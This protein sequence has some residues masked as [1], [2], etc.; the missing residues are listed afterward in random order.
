M[1]VVWAALITLLQWLRLQSFFAYEFEDDALY[2]QLLYNIGQGH[3]FENSIHPGHRPSHLVAIVALLWPFYALLGSGHVALMLIKS[4]LVG[5]GA[6]ALYLLGRQCDLSDR[7]AS[8][9]AG[10]YLLCPAT[11]ALALS[12]FRPLAISVGPLLFL[13]W[14]FHGKRFRPFMGLAALTLLFREDLGVT[15]ALFSLVAAIRK[16]SW[17]WRIWPA[18]IGIV[19]MAFVT[20]AIL[21]SG[22]ADTMGNTNVADAGGFTDRIFQILDPTHIAAGLCLMLP[23]MF[24]PLG[25]WEVLIGLLGVAAIL[26]NRREFVGNLV[27]LSAPAVAACFGAAVIAFKKWN[28]RFPWLLK[29][30]VAAS[31]LIHVQ[32]WIPPTFTQPG[33]STLKPASAEADFRAAWSPFSPQ[34]YTQSDADRNRWEAVAHIPSDAVVSATGHFLPALM[35]RSEIYEVGHWK[36]PWRTANYFI[37]EPTSLYSGA[38]GYIALDANNLKARL[39]EVPGRLEVIFEKGNVRVLR[40]HAEEQRV[41]KPS[42]SRDGQGKR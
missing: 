10:V 3:F 24:L 13:I 1:V 30:V 40:R 20:T 6:I 23:L 38:G 21:P 9:W 42:V 36:T 16:Y 4:L 18:A 33:H 31:L 29:G 14:A 26:L 19:W 2:H 25:A 39:A 22:Y 32:P 17:Q 34:Y 15:I 8:I 11:I 7:T 27:H 37:V 35:P 41:P 12:T 5:S 28:G